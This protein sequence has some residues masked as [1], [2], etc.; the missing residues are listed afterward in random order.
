M[1][2]HA[3]GIQ[4]GKRTVRGGGEVIT[5]VI[6]EI[7]CVKPQEEREGKQKEKK[8]KRKRRR[9]GRGGWE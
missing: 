5:H 4:E 9:R 7:D 6:M 8:M 2:G 1:E 3:R